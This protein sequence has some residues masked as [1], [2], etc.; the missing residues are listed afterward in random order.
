MAAIIELV[1]DGFATALVAGAYYF[2][3]FLSELSI[4]PRISAALPLY[5]EVRR[6]EAM[7]EDIRPKMVD[8][9]F[10]RLIV[11]FDNVFF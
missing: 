6:R 9:L 11:D 4:L 2:A 1:L 10:Q 7:A 8:L 5:P 3:P